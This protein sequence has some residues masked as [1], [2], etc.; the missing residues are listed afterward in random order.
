MDTRDKYG[1]PH[2]VR[3]TQSGHLEGR[4]YAVHAPI[5]ATFFMTY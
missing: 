4:V 5:L 1:G 2:K 3:L